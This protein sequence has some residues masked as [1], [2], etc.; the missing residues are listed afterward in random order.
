M[1]ISL[2][3]RSSFFKPAKVRGLAVEEHV[4]ALEDETAWVSLDAQDPLHAKDVRPFVQQEIAQPIVELRLVEIAGD[5]DADGIHFRVV[6]VFVRVLIE[7]VRIDVENA[8][9]VEPFDAEDF[10][11]AGRAGILAAVHQGA[12]RR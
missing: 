5:G 12:V 3:S 8:F 6:L 2:L 7:K 4:N 9:E 1:K 10:F 11:H